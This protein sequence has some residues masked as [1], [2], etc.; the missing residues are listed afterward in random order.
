MEWNPV[1]KQMPEYEDLLFIRK[2]KDSY[3]LDIGFY[4]AK[5]EENGI[6]SLIVNKGGYQLRDVVYWLVIKLP[7]ECNIDDEDDHID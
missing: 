4:I 1:S 7:P 5:D 2:I 3:A 6:S